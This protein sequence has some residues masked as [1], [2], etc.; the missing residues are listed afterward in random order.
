MPEERFKSGSQHA[1][2]LT[3]TMCELLAAVP[4][5]RGAHVFSFNGGKLWSNSLVKKQL[6]SLMLEH[7]RSKARERGDN[8]ERG[9]AGAVGGA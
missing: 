8:A 3:D 4:H 1:V 9:H 2:P 7:L 5:M 6:D